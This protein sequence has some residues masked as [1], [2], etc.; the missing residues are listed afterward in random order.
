MSAE[1]DEL[2][3]IAVTVAGSELGRHVRE[4]GM[5][6]RGPRVDVYLR[7]ANVSQAT[8]NSTSEQGTLDRRW[9]GMFIYFCYVQAAN[10]LNKTLPF[11]SGV[12]WGGGSLF[13]WAHTTSDVIISDGN[14]QAG[15]IFAIRNNHIGMATG[16]AVNNIFPT[17]EGNQSEV[18][19][20][21]DGI[22]RKSQNIANCRV[23]VRI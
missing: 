8:M 17:I 10:R 6:N 15:D 2:R 3:N 19:N 9:C 14:V 13:R 5:Q 23:I 16:A 11:N 18:E 12:L 1:F 7:T 4:I 22:T 20:N 21:W